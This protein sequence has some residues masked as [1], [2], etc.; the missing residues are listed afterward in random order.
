MILSSSLSAAVVLYPPVVPSS[1]CPNPQTLQ[2]LY[3]NAAGLRRFN[4]LTLRIYSVP[5][6]AETTISDEDIPAM[7]EPEQPVTV[8]VKHSPY[9]AVELSGDRDVCL[10]PYSVILRHRHLKQQHKVVAGNG[11]NGGVSNTPAKSTRGKLIIHGIP[12]STSSS[13]SQST[14]NS[15]PTGSDNQVNPTIAVQPP[16]LADAPAVSQPSASAAP[17]PALPQSN[18][19]T[20]SVPSQATCGTS[21]GNQVT[22][23]QRTSTG[24]L[25][26]TRTEHM[27]RLPAR[28]KTVWFSSRADDLLAAP[29]FIEPS[30]IR[31]GDLYVHYTP[32]DRKQIWLRTADARWETIELYHP[33]PYITGYV[34]NIVSSGEPSWV[35]SETIRTYEGRLKKRRRDAVK[36]AKDGGMDVTPTGTS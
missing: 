4:T 27:M 1:A 9:P 13:G 5:P 28:D 22:G 21:Q 35:K 25:S 3:S 18:Q 6:H 33:H 34:L 20:A 17:V 36:A 7:I 12:K 19:A 8:Y 32:G 29:P 15:V 2:P 31:F 16:S 30:Q 26:V 14:S 24:L 11:L 10:K 23:G